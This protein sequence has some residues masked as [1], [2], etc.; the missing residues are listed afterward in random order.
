VV[1][2]LVLSGGGL[3]NLLTG[4]IQMPVEYHWN[5]KT[6]LLQTYLSGRITDSEI[7]EH[8]RQ[9]VEDENI[10]PVIYEIIYTDDV[11]DMQLT[12]ASLEDAAR[13]LHTH[14]DVLRGQRVAIVAMSDVNF[15][16]ARM[17]AMMADANP[18]SGKVKVFREEDAAMQWLIEEGYKPASE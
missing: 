1:L 14:T 17:Y 7:I 11:V 6:H 5:A 12:P 16:M 8:A 3:Q 15:G 13:N 9:T 4:G 2:G 18:A 10:K